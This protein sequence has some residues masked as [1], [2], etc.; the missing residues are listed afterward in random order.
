MLKFLYK[1][2]L[3]SILSI[4]LLNLNLMAF[5]QDIKPLTNTDKITTNSNSD[6]T[7]SAD[8]NDNKKDEGKGGSEMM[9]SITMIVIGFLATRLYK[10]TPK[11]TDIYIA[12]VGGVAFIVGEILS[13]STFKED[14]KALEKKDGPPDAAQI[15]ALT[16]LKKS[17]EAAKKS[18]SRKKMLQMASAAAF[19]VAAVM[20][21]FMKSKEVVDATK[22]A[23]TLEATKTTAAT[24]AQQLTAA[25]GAGTAT[26]CPE[27]PIAKAE[28]PLTEKAKIDAKK[29]IIN[30]D[31]VKPSKEDAAQ[32]KIDDALFEADIKAMEAAAK[33]A[34]TLNPIFT[35]WV[36]KGQIDYYQMQ[37]DLGAQSSSAKPD[38]PSKDADAPKALKDATPAEQQGVLDFLKSSKPGGASLKIKSSTSIALIL[39]EKILDFAFPSAKAGTM[40]LLMLA[41][42]AAISMILGKTL[43]AKIDTF[44]AASKNRGIIWGVLAGLAFMASS[45]STKTLKKI[46]DN[47]K[48]IDDILKGVNSATTNGTTIGDNNASSTPEVAAAPST[49]T[50]GASANA[51][52]TPEAITS[53]TVATPL[54][55]AVTAPGA[56]PA[57]VSTT[58]IT[59]AAP[60]STTPLA[61]PASSNTTPQTNLSTTTGTG[62]NA[63]ARAAVKNNLSKIPVSNSVAATTT[64]TASSNL[65]TSNASGAI[66]FHP[67]QRTSCLDHDGDKNC[68]SIRSMAMSSPGFQQFPPSIQSLASEALAIGDDLTETNE[69]KK[70][71]LMAIDSFGA[72]QP[73]VAKLLELRK[74][75]LNNQLIQSSFAPINFAKE[76]SAFLASANNDVAKV[77][78]DHNMG[79]EQYL[80]LI[81]RS[82]FEKDLESSASKNSVGSAYSATAIDNQSGEGATQSGPISN[83]LSE[84]IPEP[85]A[86]VKNEH[87]LD[88]RTNDITTDSHASLFDLISSRYIK[89][90]YRRLIDEEVIEQK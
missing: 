45:G 69:V 48:K 35:P 54:P 36:K 5:A 78:R 80:K 49:Q 73:E 61:Q 16:K 86:E 56:I 50:L 12:M 40:S 81:G 19:G 68:K 28:Q 66:R 30:H 37:A 9:S 4:A 64:K 11:T 13:T 72:K 90:A 17:Y 24:A 32:A 53:T 22:V 25:C 42:G 38:D 89:S 79:P 87:E 6:T 26:A 74:A 59:A 46:E 47:I 1:K 41:G 43:G 75:N 88:I 77:L 29:R 8:G 2:I 51:S 58:P 60:T 44:L 76:E 7:K 55:D 67:T 18:T 34:P 39:F 23:A 27:V 62:Q 33:P 3:V 83:P 57:P 85:I 65:E 84:K 10:Y 15:E 20:A 82:L 14:A 63:I 70:S 52:S 21:F 31:R 71:T